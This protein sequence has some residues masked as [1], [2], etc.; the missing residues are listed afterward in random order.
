MHCV[1]ECRPIAWQLLDSD[2]SANPE[3]VAERINQSYSSIYFYLVMA[4]DIG[5]RGARPL[6]VNASV[7]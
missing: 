4:P 2:V 5:L 6:R 7:A 3:A 1:C